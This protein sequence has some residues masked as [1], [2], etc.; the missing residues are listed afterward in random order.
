MAVRINVTS[1]KYYNQFRNGVDFDLNPTEYT[2]NLAGSVM[3]KVKVLYNV[4]ISWGISYASENFEWD[5]TTSGTTLTIVSN[6]GVNFKD[7][8]FSAG[9]V[10]DMGI[11]VAGIG[12]PLQD[13]VVTSVTA[14]VMIVI[15][16][17]A[18]TVPVGI[19][20]MRIECKSPLTALKYKFGLIGNNV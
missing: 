16:S 9:D 15:T 7:E 20:G 8:G 5:L 18:Y 19:I 17:A 4:D 11:N 1:Q 14:N 2:N 3:E 13:N 10:V 12:I 6:N